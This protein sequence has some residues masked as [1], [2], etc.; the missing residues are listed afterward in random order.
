MSVSKEPVKIKLTQEEMDLI[1]QY[2]REQGM[3][4][5]QF[6]V[7]AAKISSFVYDETEKKGGRVLVERRNKRLY[8][9]SLVDSYTKDSSL[10]NI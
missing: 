2:A 9:F 8:E 7:E 6:I 1:E 4:V 10:Q 3:P 5:H